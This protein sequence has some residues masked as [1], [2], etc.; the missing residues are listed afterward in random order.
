M[1]VRCVS[2]RVHDLS[3]IASSCLYAS[4]CDDGGGGGGGS[5]EDW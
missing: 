4:R 2:G 5:D 3:E 1:V